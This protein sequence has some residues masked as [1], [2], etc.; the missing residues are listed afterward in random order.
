MNGFF[1][2]KEKAIE[3]GLTEN[4]IIASELQNVIIAITDRDI[5]EYQEEH[6][7]PKVSYSDDVLNSTGIWFYKNYYYGFME[8]FFS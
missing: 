3:L 8:S 6:E 7:L 4:P 2:S 1:I 5:F